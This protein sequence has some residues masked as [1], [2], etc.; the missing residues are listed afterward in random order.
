MEKRNG[1]K[2]L[3]VPAMVMVVGLGMI[4]VVATEICNVIKR[5]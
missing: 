4:G 2:T 5:K 1:E 3:S